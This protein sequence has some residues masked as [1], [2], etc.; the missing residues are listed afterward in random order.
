MGEEER[1]GTIGFDGVEDLGAEGDLGEVVD[2]GVGE[3]EELVRQNQVP[4]LLP[5]LAGAAVHLARRRGSRFRSVRQA[6]FR[7]LRSH[8]ASVGEFL[9]ASAAG[10]G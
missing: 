9:A 3:K 10:L 7:S 1:H 6:G 8:G 5:I 2:G 4:L